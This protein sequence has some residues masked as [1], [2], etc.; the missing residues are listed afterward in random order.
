ML[1]GKVE[2]PATKVLV[3]M[4]PLTETFLAFSKLLKE[5]TVPVTTTVLIVTVLLK[6][7][8]LKKLVVTELVSAPS[9]HVSTPDPLV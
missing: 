6:V 5:A 2:P 4:V 1:E 8:G 7:T 3:V 9:A